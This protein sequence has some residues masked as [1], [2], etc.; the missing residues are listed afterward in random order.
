MPFFANHFADIERPEQRIAIHLKKVSTT[1]PS[2]DPSARTSAQ[3]EIESYVYE[4]V[5]PGQGLHRYRSETLR[6][7][8]QTITHRD[9]GSY[10][11]DAG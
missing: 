11:A 8:G 1:L 10:G 3:Q 2:H 5:R 6:I 7:S 4:G 9:Q